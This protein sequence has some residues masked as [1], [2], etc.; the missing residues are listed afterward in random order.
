MTHEAVEA[1]RQVFGDAYATAEAYH[2]LL[3]TRGIEWGL[4]GPRE[5]DRLWERHLLNSVAVADLLPQGAT[6]CDVGSGAGLPGFPL[7]ISRPDLTV[8]LLEPLLRR[9][10]FLTGVVAELG[11]DDRVTVERG[12]AEDF[13]ATFDVVTCR[14]VAPLAKLLPWTLPLLGQSGHLVALKGSSAADEIAACRKLLE[15]ERLEAEVLSVRA[16]PSVEATTAV[17]V[18]RG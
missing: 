14:A 2:D 16:H 11:L 1:A 15:H 10:N 18:R 9:A 12:R 3:A 13:D 8:T 4:M 5:I 17:R 7:A 6:V